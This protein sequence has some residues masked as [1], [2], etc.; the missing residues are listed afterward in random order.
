MHSDRCEASPPAGM[1][2]RQTRFVTHYYY[3]LPLLV[4]RQYYCP[5]VTLFQHGFGKQ[6]LQVGGH[7]LFR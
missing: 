6:L 1:T 3:Y 5:S 7:S 2:L 4:C